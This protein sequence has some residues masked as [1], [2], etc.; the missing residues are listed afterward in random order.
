MG[1]RCRT[2]RIDVDQDVKVE[3]DRGRLVIDGEHDHSEEKEGPTLRAVSTAAPDFA[4][5]PAGQQLRGPARQ[6]GL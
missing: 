4:S 1:K 5:A 3:V 2:P 6:R